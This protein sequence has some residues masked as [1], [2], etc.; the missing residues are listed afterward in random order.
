MH[1]AEFFLHLFPVSTQKQRRLKL[2][3]RQKVDKVFF[4]SK[5]FK[6]IIKNTYDDFSLLLLLPKQFKLL[7]NLR[8]PILENLEI[9]S[10]RKTPTKALHR[11]CPLRLSKSSSD[12]DA[13]K[14][15]TRASALTSARTFLY[16]RFNGHRHTFGWIKIKSWTCKA[17]RTGSRN[18]RKLKIPCIPIVVNALILYAV[19]N[20]APFVPLLFSDC[21]ISCLTWTKPFTHAQLFFLANF[22]VLNYESKMRKIFHSSK[23]WPNGANFKLMRKGNQRMVTKVNIHVTFISVHLI[24]FDLMS[25]SSLKWLSALQ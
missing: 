17:L 1:A 7:I 13:I 23:I 19:K 12:C 22:A 25:R 20:G 21:R 8:I 18:A 6:R 2:K 9:N 15:S 24:T 10:K 16:A 11:F 4:N 3:L 14:V 5:S